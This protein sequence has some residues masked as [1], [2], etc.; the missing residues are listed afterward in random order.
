MIPALLIFVFYPL[1][2]PRFFTDLGFV[3][4]MKM[5]SSLSYNVPTLQ[6]ICNPYAAMPSLHFSWTLLAGVS[7]VCLAKHWWAKLMGALLPS[8]MLISI[9][10]TGNHFIL[11]AV[12]GALTIFVSWGMALSFRK[13]ANKAKSHKSLI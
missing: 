12:A 3:D 13:L 1:A 9:V 8:T 7:I 5:Y 4:T 10:A 11:D 6:A 2:P